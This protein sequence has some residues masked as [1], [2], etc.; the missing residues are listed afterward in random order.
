MPRSAR[1]PAR[2]GMPDQIVSATAP[3]RN[4]SALSGP[5]TATTTTPTTRN[6]TRV[7]PAGMRCSRVVPGRWLPS[8]VGVI[9]ASCRGPVV[10]HGARG[11]PVEDDAA[12]V[13]DQ[14]AVA[15]GGELEVVG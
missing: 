3:A 10:L 7:A 2:S 12:A 13:H 6:A 4:A 1:S 14:R 15:A 9:V 8:R 5:R 11:R